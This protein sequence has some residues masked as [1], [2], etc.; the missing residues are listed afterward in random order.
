MI[1]NYFRTY[2]LRF[3]NMAHT[4]EWVK[5]INKMFISQ[6]EPKYK[7]YKDIRS[8]EMSDNYK[9]K[10]LEEVNEQIEKVMIKLKE[11]VKEQ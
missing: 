3:K 10:K 8:Q 4:G 9:L 11:L 7:L 6:T 2:S 5:E 1:R